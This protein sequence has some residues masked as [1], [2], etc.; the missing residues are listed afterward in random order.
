MKLSIV[1]PCYNEEKNIPLIL[2]RFAKVVEQSV[3]LILVNGSTDGSAEVFRKELVKKKYSFARLV[4]V[5]ENVGYGHGI[6]TG[7]KSAKGDILAW[8]HADMQTDPA[9][10]IKGY[11]LLMNLDDPEGAV[12]KGR[13]VNRRLGETL[14][15]LGMS[16][17]ASLVLWRFLFDVNA[18]PKVFPRGFY[19]QMKRPPKDF[20][21]DLYWLYLAKIKRYK[22]KVLPVYFKKRIHGESK[23]AF[24]FVSRMK[25]IWRT[26]KYI[27]IL[28]RYA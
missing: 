3:E 6:S 2:E 17:L 16:V 21:L 18:Q 8:T 4:T 22:V 13:R 26:V 5:K 14:F 7:L 23:W 19:K 25:T 11:K 24:S 9:D 15:T 12:V 27:F 28:R 10:V 1:V 20:S